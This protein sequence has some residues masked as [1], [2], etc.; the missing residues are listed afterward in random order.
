MSHCSHNRLK[1]RLIESGKN[2]GTYNAYCTQQCKGMTSVTIATAD[3]L[4]VYPK[5][6]PKQ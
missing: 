5:G 1:R 3:I 6:R 4:A 2:E